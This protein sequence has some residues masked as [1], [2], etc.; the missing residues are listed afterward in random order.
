MNHAPEPSAQ[1]ERQYHTYVTHR[2]PW[3]VR[4]MWAAFW[5]GMLWYLI[6]YAVPMARNYF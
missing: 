4:I 1:E 6:K 3:Y 2:I 5:I